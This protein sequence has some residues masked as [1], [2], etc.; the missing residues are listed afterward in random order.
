MAIVLAFSLVLAACSESAQ[1]TT[2]DEAPET[3][4]IDQTAYDTPTPVPAPTQAPTA[5]P[6]PEPTAT[7][8]PTATPKPEP[9]PTQA[10]TATPKPRAHANG[11]RVNR[12][13]PHRTVGRRQTPPRKDQP[14]LEF[15]NMYDIDALETLYEPN[16]WSEQEAEVRSNMQ[17]FKNFGIKLN[18]EEP[19]P[20]SE[21][22]PGKW[23]IRQT[24]SFTQGSINM[25]FVYEEFAGEW[26][27][28]YA[29]T[30]RPEA[31]T[32][33]KPDIPCRGEPRLSQLPLPSNRMS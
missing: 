32:G 33:F 30:S 26:L 16:Y 27:L 21:I 2:E 11:G 25:V 13:R 31:R 9:T 20:P 29:Q 18:P 19:A 1:E 22:A 6:K 10:P 17:S 28:T 23:E 7:Q 4:T 15:Y 24:V 8:A 14:T 5:T 12:I 3:L